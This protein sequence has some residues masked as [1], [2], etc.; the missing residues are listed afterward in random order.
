[1]KTPTLLSAKQRSFLTQL[2]LRAWKKL[3]GNGAIEETFDSY[4][5]R[6]AK[7]HSGHTISEAPAA[8]FDDLYIAFKTEIGD[9]DEAFQRASERRTNAQRQDIHNIKQQ[10][11]RAGLTLGYAIAIARDEWSEK[12]KLSFD[13][14]ESLPQHATRKL[15][16]TITARVNARL[17]KAE[18]C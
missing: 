10:L 4:R 1:M 5:H 8:A 2:A 7:R 3:E 11:E 9:M 13:V 14:L 6:I 12:L 18:S 16:Y 17:K 15:L